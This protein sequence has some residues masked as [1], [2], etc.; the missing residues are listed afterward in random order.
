[1][2]RVTFVKPTKPTETNSAADETNVAENNPLQRE[3][4][5]KSSEKNSNA[6]DIARTTG[7]ASKTD[8]KQ[9][10]VHNSALLAMIEQELKDEI[11]K[12]FANTKES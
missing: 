10:P 9:N 11:K 5:P 12:E 4:D 3:G 7:P 2:R 6:K 8:Q 1:M